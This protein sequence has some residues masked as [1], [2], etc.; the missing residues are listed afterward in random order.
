MSK[1]VMYG[2]QRKQQILGLIK[3]KKSAS[4]N[5]LAQ[6]FDVTT[7]TIRTDLTELEKAGEV[8]RTHGGAILKSDIA[9]EQ[10]LNER[11]NEDK[12]IKVAFKALDLIEEDDSILIDTG[13]ST[14]AFA[15]IL[16]NSDISRL[17]IFTNDFEIAKL[18]EGKSEF[19]VHI[20]GGRV[21]KGFHYSY[22][23][24]AISELRKYKFDK[25][26]LATSS[27]SF[28]KGLTTYHTETADLKVEMI[29][30]ASNKILLLD[31]TKINKDS[32]A[33]FADL[34]EIDTVVVDNE[35]SKFDYQNLS[36]SIDNVI[37]A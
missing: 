37:I 36:E 10:F 25:L 32:F 33:Q 21:R 17:R 6:Y 28:D 29:N 30:S 14:A 3:E 13:T 8:I 34:K 4:V 12:K 9:H 15:R 31:S 1:K 18:L 7:A 26:V 23:G 20:L 24:T 16:A 11:E 19:D 5:E 22:G 2:E 35:I 27:L